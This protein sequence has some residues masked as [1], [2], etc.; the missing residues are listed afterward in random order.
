M[1]PLQSTMVTP[2][3]CRMRIFM[4]IREP[5]LKTLLSCGRAVNQQN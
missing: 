2:L 1:R 5:P 3:A 4:L